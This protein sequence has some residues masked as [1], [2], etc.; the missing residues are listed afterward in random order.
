MLVQIG[1]TLGGFTFIAG[2]ITALALWRKTKAEVKKTD[3]DAASVLTDSAL[4]IVKDLRGELAETR[5]QMQALRSH[6][7]RLEGLLRDRGVPVPDF[8]WP[9]RNGAR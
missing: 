1:A 6:M 3:V 8:D 5:Q 9:P 2:I 7:G 4:S